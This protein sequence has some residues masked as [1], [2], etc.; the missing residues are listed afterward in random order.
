MPVFAR[1]VVGWLAVPVFVALV[2]APGIAQTSTMP[3]VFSG[4]LINLNTQIN[5][6]GQ[7]PVD[8][9]INRWSTAGEREQLITVLKERG[10]DGLLEMMQSVERIGTIRIPGS[11]N[12]DFH[13]ALRGEAPGGG[14]AVTLIADR[15]VGYTEAVEGPRTLDYRFMVIQFQVNSIGQGG[16]QISMVTKVEVDRVTGE[17]NLE[18]WEDLFVTLRSL[19]RT[20]GR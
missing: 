7:T 1:L 16:G 10:R 11:L 2:T 15:P 17:I 20:S 19:R 3:L 8:I 14:M 6:P 13:F 5:L 9:T 4:Q 18:T 12:Y